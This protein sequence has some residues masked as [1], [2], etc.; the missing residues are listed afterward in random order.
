[1]DSTIPAM[2]AKGPI[3]VSYTRGQDAA[4]RFFQIPPDLVVKLKSLISLSLFC[5]YS[6]DSTLFKRQEKPEI[7]V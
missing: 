2:A 3:T 1:V 4:R 6:D 5:N 7:T